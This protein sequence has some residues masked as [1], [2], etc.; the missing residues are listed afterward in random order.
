MF[1]GNLNS[2]G[3]CRM[4]NYTHLSSSDRCRFYTLLEMKLSLT[5]IGKR[6]GKHRS[7]LY[8]ELERNKE[9]EG[10]LPRDCA[11]K[12]RRKSQRKAAKQNRKEWVSTRLYCE[13]FKERLEP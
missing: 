5:N 9:P 4:G 2:I 10:Y 1:L 6:L 7:T 13:K 12:G 3:D 11:N 8:R